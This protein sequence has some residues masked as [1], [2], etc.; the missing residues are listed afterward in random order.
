MT[1]AALEQAYEGPDLNLAGQGRRLA[2]Y[3][4]ELVGD[5]TLDTPFLLTYDLLMRTRNTGQTLDFR[6]GFL[7]EQELDY[8]VVGALGDVPR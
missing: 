5:C 8:V 2:E 3:V 4:L 6:S 1:E 7:A